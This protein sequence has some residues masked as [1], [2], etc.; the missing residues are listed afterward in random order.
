MTAAFAK[1]IGLPVRYQRVFVD[2]TWS[3]SGDV[4]LSDRARQ[5]DV[6]AGGRSDGGFGRNDSDIDDDRFSSAARPPR[7]AHAELDEETIVGDVHEQPGRRIVHAADSIDD[8]YWWA[9][10]A[11]EQD[12][13]F[14]GVVQH[15][16]RRS[17]G[18]TAT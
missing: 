2:D 16:W 7:R 4:Y 11:I 8:A 9:R 15:A 12:P 1:E 5:P 3:R 17:T 13:G 6:S 10:A 18:A 14:I